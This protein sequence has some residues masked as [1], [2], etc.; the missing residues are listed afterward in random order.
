[1]KTITDPLTSFSTSARKLGLAFLLSPLLFLTGCITNPPIQNSTGV[2]SMEVDPS[3][4]GPVSGVGIESRD[5][6]AM[7]DQMVRDIMADQYF[8]SLAVAGKRPRVIIDSTR[9]KN[10]SSQAIDR[11][12][13]TGRLYTALNRAA[14]QRIQFVKRD[15]VSRVEEERALKRSGTTDLGTT[16]L[17]KATLSAD[18][19]LAGKI[20]SQ[21]SRNTKTG[22]VQRYTIISFDLVDAETA[23]GVWSN[24]YT[25]ERASADDVV[26]R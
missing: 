19:Y 16:G 13:I 3:R 2:S 17:V 18:F 11:D 4:K 24:D 21:D 10:Q 12:L 14:R 7:A 6:V 15:E 25:V 8:A 5:Y 22:L 1:M 23:E 9:F 20:L 26:Y